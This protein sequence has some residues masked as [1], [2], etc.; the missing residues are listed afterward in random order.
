MIFRKWTGRI[1]TAQADEYVR[2]VE[3]TGGHHYASTEGNLGYQIL[4]RDLGD[5]TSEVSTISWWT[6]L[7]AVR[8][9][10]GEDYA[11]ARY[12]AEDDQYLIDRPRWVEHHEVRHSDLSRLKG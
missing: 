2:Y 6:D 4:L 9:F 3:E 8:R 10:A 11:V 1:R 7:D 12:Y 5:G